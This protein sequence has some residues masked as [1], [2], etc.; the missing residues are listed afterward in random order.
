MGEWYVNE[1]CVDK[2]L[3]DIARVKSG[4]FRFVETCCSKEPLFSCHYRDKPSMKSCA[5]SPP[6]DK[7]KPSF[8]AKEEQQAQ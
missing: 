2:S 8:W 5:G 3:S 6:I 1:Q 4:D 7:G